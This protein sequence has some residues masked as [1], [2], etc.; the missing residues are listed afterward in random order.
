M[1]LRDLFIYLIILLPQEWPPISKIVLISLFGCLM[2]SLS[3]LYKVITTSN[4]TRLLKKYFSVFSF[5]SNK[6][7]D[8][9]RVRGTEREYIFWLLNANAELGRHQ[10]PGTPYRSPMWVIFECL[11][12]HLLALRILQQEAQ[13]KAEV[14]LK[15]QDAK[16]AIWHGSLKQYLHCCTKWM[17]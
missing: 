2:E 10:E 5:H 1:H 9:V 7:G 11:N 14:R 6:R 16:H 4:E 13:L 15:I 8:R 3:F 17:G 12:F